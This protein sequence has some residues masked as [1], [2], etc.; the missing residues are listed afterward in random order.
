MFSRLHSRDREIITVTAA[1]EWL[2]YCI[3][4]MLLCCSNRRFK[5]R[6]LCRDKDK[7]ERLRKKGAEIREIDYNDSGTL[8]DGVKDSK[9]VV[10]VV[11]NDHDRVDNAEALC[12]VSRLE[13]SPG[14]V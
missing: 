8:D 2:G 5:V 11:E 14:E 9:W 12:D 13:Y 7:G 4:D 1:D 6:A 3:A 10:F